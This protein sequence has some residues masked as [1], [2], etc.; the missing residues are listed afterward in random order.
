[1]L[2]MAREGL[3]LMYGLEPTFARYVER[4]ELKIVLEDWATTGPG[5][6]IYY[7]SRRQVPTGLRLLIDVI[8]NYALSAP[9]RSVERRRRLNS[10]RSGPPCGAPLPDI[11]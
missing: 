5:Y 6:H 11:C 1:M 10:G 7:S 2:T 3:G 9:S 4:G 8:R